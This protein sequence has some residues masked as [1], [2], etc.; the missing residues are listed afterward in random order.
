MIGVP[1]ASDT[2]YLVWHAPESDGE[3]LEGS[4]RETLRGLRIRPTSA[5]SSSY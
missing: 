3:A 4:I 1:R 2:L 5:R